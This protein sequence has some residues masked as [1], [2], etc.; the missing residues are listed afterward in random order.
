MERILSKE[1]VKIFIL[2]CEQQGVK[3]GTESACVCVCKGGRK[4]MPALPSLSNNSTY[5]DIY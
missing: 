4:L 3:G 1:N 2:L 5:T